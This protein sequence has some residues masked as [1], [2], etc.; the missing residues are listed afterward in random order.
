MS[1]KQKRIQA[2]ERKI[3][4]FSKQGE[5]AIP[6]VIGFL[7]LLIY[8]RVF[9]NRFTNWDDNYYILDNPY[10]K[11][12]FEN[13]KSIFSTFYQGNYHPL[14]MFF[15]SLGYSIG[16]LNPWIYHL[17]NLLLHV[18]NTF[19]VY[20]FIRLLLKQKSPKNSAIP[21]YV[22]LLTSLL[23]GI[24]TLQTESVAWI[25]E[26]KTV[27][28]AFFFLIAL[29]CYLKYIESGK[30]KYFALSLSF[31]I[32]SVLSKAMAVSLLLCLPLIDYYV[33]RKVTVRKHF[34]EKLPF[35]LI[36]LFF[37]IVAIYAQDNAMKGIA[38]S[39]SLLDKVSIAS[40]GV[41]MYVAKTILPVNLSAFYGYPLQ[42][43]HHI[44]DYFYF[45]PF[46][47]ISAA[48][49][50]YIFCRKYPWSLFGIFF[51]LVNI[52]LVLQLLPVG[53]TIMA[54][55]YVYLPMIGFGFITSYLFILIFEKFRKYRPYLRAGLSLYLLILTA[56]T[57]NRIGVWKDSVTLW[58]NVI[59]NNKGTNIARA[60]YNR[61]IAFNEDKNYNSALNDFSK[62]ISIFP[63][64]A[65]ALYS[66][67]LVYRSLGKQEL[68]LE[69]FSRAIL[70]NP[71]K[72]DSFYYRGMTNVDL[73]RL[74]EA[75]GDF[76]EA[77]KRKPD[78]VEALSARALAR[79][80]L[81]DNKGAIIDLTAAIDLRTANPDVFLTRGYL[82]SL[83]GDYAKAIIDYNR[84][85]EIQPDNIFYYKTRAIAETHA[86][87][88][89]D[90]INDFNIVLQSEKDPLSLYFRGYSKYM[91]G[92]ND[93]GCADIRQAKELGFLEIDPKIGIKCHL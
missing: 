54:D 67:A 62:A 74:P 50:I 9:A 68:A 80:Q 66:R 28:Y 40:Y 21:R 73:N 83:T 93:E 5:N 52:L 31:F 2:Q 3:T 78:H 57:F 75:I 84:A 1:D 65:D 15:Y 61:G 25:S 11:W 49:L 35:L 63:N 4:L 48:A 27:L 29:I 12:N 60:Y 23:F 41:F 64:N 10:L 39:F 24:H 88:Y 55:R 36:S 8:A 59:K 53:N 82:I 20:I 22:P 81:R 14:T 47:I 69:D 46:F 44:P 87:L 7:I 71:K 85:I 91:L 43:N 51:F 38:S 76:S 34:I 30:I 16:G 89:Q 92:R 70:L 19:F 17:L 37:G 6:F 72:A 58:N 18:A 79:G 90:A 77:I 45:F 56:L 13:L 32:F 33:Q 26:L 42:A 86:N